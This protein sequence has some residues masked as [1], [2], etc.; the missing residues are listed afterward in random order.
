[1]AQGPTTAG[2]PH[3]CIIGVSIHW[4][5]MRRRY[6]L[7]MQGQLCCRL[8]SPFGPGQ[9]HFRLGWGRHFWMDPNNIEQA[10]K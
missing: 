6:A 2:Y 4:Y 10:S 3:H 7:R 5:A 9:N 1:M 8:P